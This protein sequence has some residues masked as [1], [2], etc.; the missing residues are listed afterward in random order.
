MNLNRRIVKYASYI[1]S[2]ST[3]LSLRGDRSFAKA[4]E[5]QWIHKSRL[6]WGYWTW[7]WTWRGD[8]VAGRAKTFIGSTCLTSFYPVW[9]EYVS[10]VVQRIH[11]ERNTF[12]AGQI[13]VPTVLWTWK[14]RIWPLCRILICRTLFPSSSYIKEDSFQTHLLVLSKVVAFVR[15][16]LTEPDLQIKRVMNL[17]VSLSRS[18]YVK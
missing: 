8:A 16:T 17:P 5:A 18:P 3:P 15:S 10:R 12:P 6:L 9:F 7:T 4:E 11:R 14:G 13:P 1:C 2:S